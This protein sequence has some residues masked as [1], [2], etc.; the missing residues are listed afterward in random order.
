MALA[1][2]PDGQLVTCE[3]DSV[4]LDLARDTWTRSGVSH[5]VLS[6]HFVL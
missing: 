1:L 2:P 3:K 4:T 6:R 5:K